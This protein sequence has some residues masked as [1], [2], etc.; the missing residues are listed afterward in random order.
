MALGEDLV[1]THRPEVAN[2]ESLDWC[3][4]IVGGRTSFGH[5]AHLL[6]VGGSPDSGRQRCLA[7]VVVRPLSASRAMSCSS[8]RGRSEVRPLPNRR[9]P[10]GPARQPTRRSG[11]GAAR[12]S[13]RRGSVV[14]RRPMHRCAYEASPPLRGCIP[15]RPHSPRL[16]R[17][18]CRSEDRNRRWASDRESSPLF[19]LPAITPCR[20][21]G[22][23]FGIAC[24]R[25]RRKGIARIHDLRGVRSR[26]KHS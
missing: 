22:S 15:A 11:L 5:G 4:D 10:T 23:V 1:P 19:Y 18:A 20:S 8:S 24:L 21:R 12:E 2:P 7:A 6:A 16:L 17:R 26:H 3:G 9:Y 14:V 25:P 13:A